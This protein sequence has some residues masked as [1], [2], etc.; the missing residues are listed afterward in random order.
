MYVFILFHKNV[1][2]ALSQIPITLK[3]EPE[4]DA[5]GQEVLKCGFKIGGGIDQ[6]YQ[7]SPQG[8]TDNVSKALPCSDLVRSTYP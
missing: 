5:N 4:L 8:Y 1:S 7:K 2:F 3:K 6:D